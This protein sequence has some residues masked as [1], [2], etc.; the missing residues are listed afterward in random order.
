MQFELTKLAW[1]LAA[2][3]AERGSYPAGLEE[4]KGEYVDEIPHDVFSGRPLIYERTTDG[5]LLYSVGMNG[6]DDGGV[7]DREQGE[8]DI[9]VRVDVGSAGT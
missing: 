6:K 5:Y 2:F 4:L 8:D 3:R 1:A 7:N 9:A